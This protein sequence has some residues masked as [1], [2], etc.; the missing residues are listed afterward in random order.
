MK[1]YDVIKVAEE[2]YI[3]EIHNHNTTG[4]CWW[5]AYESKPRLEAFGVLKDIYRGSDKEFVWFS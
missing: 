2:T 1:V 4:M 5:R 3:E